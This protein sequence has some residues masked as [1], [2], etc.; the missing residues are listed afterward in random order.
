MKSTRVLFILGVVCLLGL[1]ACAS[2]SGDEIAKSAGDSE[3]HGLVTPT[4]ATPPAI[5]YIPGCEIPLP[6]KRKTK[7]PVTLE[8]KD[9]NGRE[10]NVTSTVYESDDDLTFTRAAYFVPWEN[11]WVPER[12]FR[13]VWIEEL[14]VGDRIFGYNILVEP[15]DQE[16]TAD[17]AAHSHRVIYACYDSDGDG[18]FEYSLNNSGAPQLVPTWVPSLLGF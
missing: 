15:T 5:S 2:K 13:L 3:F 11:R 17:N 6:E 4:P 14:R 16:N 12:R 8:R 9:E 18:K 1:G 10:L 7:V